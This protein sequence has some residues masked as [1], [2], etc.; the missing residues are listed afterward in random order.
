MNISK[1]EK[2]RAKDAAVGKK[3][4]RETPKG[5]ILIIKVT[6]QN[7]KETVLQVLDDEEFTDPLSVP[8]TMVLHEI[9]E[10]KDEPKA[11]AAKPTAP[12]AAKKE[13]KELK[14]PKAPKP[15]KKD[16][17]AKVGDGKAAPRVKLEGFNLR[18]HYRNR[19]AI[20]RALECEKAKEDSCRC[21]CGGALH[22]KPHKPWFEAE[23]ELF[24]ASPIGAITAQDVLKLIHKFG[25]AKFVAAHAEAHKAKAAKKAAPKAVKEV[26]KKRG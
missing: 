12:K 9:V 2:L 20:N 13:P 3:Y 26:Q 25:G 18:Q 21:R 10:A 22:G 5:K 7:A 16:R 15:P 11:K 17:M 14:A 19:L 23:N 6:E 24:N 4:I 8:H 1:G